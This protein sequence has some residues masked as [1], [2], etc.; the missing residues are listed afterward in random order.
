VPQASD[1]SKELDSFLRR[2]EVLF[3]AGRDFWDV[4][5]CVDYLLD[6]DGSQLPPRI[7]HTVE[8]GTIITYCRPFTGKPGRTITVATDLT[9]ELRDF[10]AEVMTRRHKV[11]AHTDYTEH[12]VARTFRSRAEGLALLRNLADGTVREEWDSLTDN[13]LTSLR[14]L[15]THHHHKITAELD[16]LARV[17]A[18]QDAAGPPQPLTY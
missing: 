17:A 3:L 11:Y 16:E 5:L 13:G 1:G 10:H 6:S 7:R 8:V 18:D 9:D 4:G 12:R 2:T 14:E 15:A